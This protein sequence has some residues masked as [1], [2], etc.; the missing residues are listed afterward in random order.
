[1]GGLAGGFSESFVNSLISNGAGDS[2]DGIALHMYVTGAPEPSIIDTWFSTA[3]SYVARKLPGR[4]L[5]LT[6]MGWSSCDT[7]ATKVTEDEQA[8]YLSRFMIDAATHGVR[9]VMWYNL[10][11]NG[12]STSSIDNFG[13]A[14]RTGRVKPAWTALAKFGAA[15]VASVP[16]GT[17]NPSPNGSTTLLNDLSTTA[18][19]TARSL[20]SGGSTTIAASSGRVG[21]A[22][23]LAVT[24]NYSNST[25]TGGLITMSKPVS[26]SPTALSLW[27]FGDNSN[28]TVM[29]KFV[30]STGESFESKI[31]N[32]GTANWTRMVFYLDGMN[33]NSSHSGG[34]NDGKVN[35]PI[36]VTQLHVYKPSS[37]GLTS[38]QFI[39]DDLS[40]HYGATVRGAVFIGR[41]YITQAVYSMTARDTKLSVPNTTA[42]IYD[43]GKVDGLSVT[44]QLA[45]V[46]LTPTPK[47]VISTPAVS[48]VSGPTQSP[49]TLSLVTG[50]RT[51]VTVQIYTK[52]GVLVRTIMTAQAVVS[53][54]RKVT[55]D[56]K[57]SDG[58]WALA[59]AYVYRIMISGADGRTSVLTRD[60]TLR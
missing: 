31:G 19:L 58:T 36:T 5:W 41:G 45:A 6:E 39:L 26:G 18:G 42:Y 40:A 59:G 33:P 44:D 54:P 15:T 25:A 27:G 20:G 56:G 47:Y 17:A 49:V 43:R 51:T 11:E 1:M 8:Q 22:G 32:I 53:G 37:G 4:S 16:A 52:A 30:D 48:P 55:W 3:E 13:L 46:T 35:Y 10:R 28:T 57:K 14:E 38:G 24:Y 29:L 12:T 21:G 60:V 9:G 23:G 2:F 7:C 34:N 50:D